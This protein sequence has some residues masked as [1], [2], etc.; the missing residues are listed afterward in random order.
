MLLVL[1][2]FI[3]LSLAPVGTG[4]ST[5]AL[6]QQ[7]QQQYNSISGYVS[8]EHR[9]PLAELNVELL[10]D[11]DSVIQ[12][13]KTDSGG[14]FVFRRVPYGVFQVRVQTFG[15]RFLPQT[16]RVQIERIGGFEHIGFV[17]VTKRSTEPSYAPGVV[18]V[19]K[20]PDEARKEF[21]RGTALLEKR[22]KKDGMLALEN[23]VKIFPTYFEALET[24]GSEYVKNEN[25]DQAIPVLIKATEI[26]RQA[27]QSLYPLSVA[28]YKLKQM[29]QAVES[30]RRA[31]VINPQSVNANL[32]LGM[33]LRQVSKLDEAES[34]LKQADQLA[35]RKSSEVHWQLALLLNDLKRYTEA[36]DE[37]ELFLKTEPEARDKDLIKKLIQ[38]LRQK[39]D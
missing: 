19:Q 6:T 16:Q 34:Y 10:N 32:W 36:A 21:E 28:Q 37:L 18:F 30:M 33:L 39:S 13:T 25:Y 9:N 26:N 7:P 23:A 4:V 12:R 29:P 8:D 27:Y 14:L 38:R 20:V 22:Q 31:I 1:G 24:L 11:V 2:L 5:S 35:E 3:A 15:T 17:L